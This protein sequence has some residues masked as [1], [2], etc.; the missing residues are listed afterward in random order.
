MADYLETPIG[1]QL[2][3]YRHLETANGTAIAANVVGLSLRD[4]L[5][6]EGAGHTLTSA[7]S[8]KTTG[9]Q[10]LSCETHQK[11]SAGR[12]VLPTSELLRHGACFRTL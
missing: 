8:L 1:E 9:Q 10:S 7:A 6:N 12:L 11:V 5:R 2:C 4:W 3:E